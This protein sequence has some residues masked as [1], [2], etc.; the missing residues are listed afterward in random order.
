MGDSRHSSRKVTRSRLGCETCRARKVRCD[1]RRPQCFNCERLGLVCAP[2][3]R[4]SSGDP[5]T[6]PSPALQQSESNGFH[7]AGTKRK[8][9]YRSCVECRT[10]K[11]RCSGQKPTCARCHEKS[12]SCTYEDDSEPAWKQRVAVSVSNSENQAPSTDSGLADAE[13]TPESVVSPARKIETP[14]ASIG[15]ASPGQPTNT[16]PPNPFS[17]DLSWLVAQHL[18]EHTRTRILVERYFA[19]VHHLRCFAFLHKPSF[20]Q[21][22]DNDANKNHDSNALLHIVCA[23]GALFYAVEYETS[24]NAA[25][26]INL[27]INPIDAGKHWASHAQTLILARLDKISVEALMAA[28]LLHDYEIRMGNYSNA[29]MLSAITARMAQAL[30]INLEHSTDVLCRETGSGPSASVKESRRRLMWCCYITDSLVGSGIDQLT[31]IDEADIKIQLPCN[32]RNFVLEEPCITETLEPGQMLKFLPTELLPTYPQD[33]M[34]MTAFYLRHIAT[35]RKVLTYIKHLDTAR[36]PWLPDSEFAQLDAELRY[37][38]DNL[39]ANLQ[40]TPTTLYI[41]QETSQVGA[42]CALHYAYHQ[43]M[44]DLYRI[45]APGL[46]KLRSAFGFPP[47][48]GEFLRHLQSTLFGHARSLATVMA[49]ALRHGPHAI[50]DSW[51]PTILY[52]SCKIMLFYLTQIIDP[53]LDSSRALLAETIPHV[54]NNVKALNIMR[55]MFASAGPLAQAA[56]TMLEKIGIELEEGRTG[57]QNFIPEDPYS[58]DEPDDHDVSQ[59]APGTPAQSAPDYILNP[60][61]IYNLARKSIPEKHAPQRQVPATPM[62]SSVPP[63]QLTPPAR[64]TSTPS[65]RNHHMGGDLQGEGALAPEL[66][67]EPIPPEQINFDELQSLFTSD[68][69][70]WTWQPAETAVG[71]RNE[72]AGLPPWESNALEGQLD[73]WIPSFTLNS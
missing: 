37:W 14:V 27:P 44:C 24:R 9:T 42:L 1:E 10:S 48:Q 6:I 2:P 71:S 50:A 4:G 62:P 43:T 13:M 58:N 26:P 61:S 19:N 28:V 64:G 60:L 54:R 30:Q 57:S 16:Q 8:R 3:G 72:A 56:H 51:L 21:K 68:P 53:S 52:D 11:T 20:L 23:L 7:G 15:L 36:P 41:R 12:L 55:S 38:Y 63:L 45:G 69:T 49:E 46:Y 32:E 59:S 25:L 5:T 66:R 34:G 17:D 33:C 18:P 39:P 35:R 40:F 22:L 29:F 67:G 65:N 70:G 31:L 47:E 73:A